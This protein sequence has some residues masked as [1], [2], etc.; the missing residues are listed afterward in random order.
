MAYKAGALIWGEKAVLASLKQCHCLILAY[1]AGPNITSKV[2]K[3]AR[4]YNIPIIT[5]WSHAMIQ[6]M[7]PKSTMLLGLKDASFIPLFLKE[8]PHG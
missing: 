2:I 3:K 7:I 8:E 1:D 5:K 4:F 6:S